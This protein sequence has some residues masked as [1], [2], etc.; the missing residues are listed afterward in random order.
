MPIALAYIR[1]LEIYLKFL[2]ESSL[3]IICCPLNC[4]QVIKSLVPVSPCS[5]LS[6]LW[7][8]NNCPLLLMGHE[9]AGSPSFSLIYIISCSFLT[10]T[11]LSFHVFLPKKQYSHFDSKFDNFLPISI[12]GFEYQ[13]MNRNKLI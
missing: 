8:Q 13:Q 11:L 7:F 9:F 6:L 10:S 12:S 3:T 4:P 1:H 5:G 2:Y